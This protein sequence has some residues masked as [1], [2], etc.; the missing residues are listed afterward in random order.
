MAIKPDMIGIVVRDM[1]A[2]LRFYR[3]LGLDIPHG[4]DNESY[5]QV[6]TPNGYR[7]SWNALEMIKQIDPAWTEPVGHRMELAFK[8]DSP[9]E[10]DAA[11][12]RL[13]EAGYHGYKPPWDAF[14]GQRYAIVDD[15]DGNHVSLFAELK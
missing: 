2:A 4:Q 6:I 10:V 14:W 15:S 8:C 11:H 3:M 5:V 12:A 9:A 1:G 13:T 7:L